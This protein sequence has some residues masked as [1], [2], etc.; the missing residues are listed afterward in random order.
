MN[1]LRSVDGVKPT[2]GDFSVFCV[3]L[4]NPGGRQNLEEDSGLMQCLFKFR[5]YFLGAGDESGRPGNL[6]R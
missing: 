5:N 3:A 2:R 6:V 4:Q 1:Q